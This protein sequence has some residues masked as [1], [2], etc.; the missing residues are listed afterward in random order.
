M[1]AGEAVQC[2]RFRYRQAR[3]PALYRDIIG[4]EHTPEQAVAWLGTSE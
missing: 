2:R 4:Q 1:H 3:R